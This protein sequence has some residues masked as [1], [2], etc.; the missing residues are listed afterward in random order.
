MS[1]Y[2]LVLWIVAL[3]P[4][5]LWGEGATPTASPAPAPAAPSTTSKPRTVKGKQAREKDN[6]GTEARN[7][8][9]ADTVLKSKY[10]FNGEPLEVDPD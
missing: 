1:R 3:A 7:R 9:Q 5:T 10:Q 4:A 8:F 2:W 6:E